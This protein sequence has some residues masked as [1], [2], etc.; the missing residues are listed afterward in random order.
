VIHALKFA[1]S[2][3]TPSA[4]PYVWETCR[5]SPPFTSSAQTSPA[6]HRRPS[7]CEPLSPFHLRPLDLDQTARIES[8]NRIGTE[9]SCASRSLLIRRPQLLIRPKRYP[10]MR[11]CR[12]ACSDSNE[13]RFRNLNQ[14]SVQSSEIHILCS[15]DPKIANDIPLESLKSV[16]PSSTIKSYILWVQF[17]TN[18]KL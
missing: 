3:W 13:F 2:R 1:K 10:P 11:N 4:H 16:E 17:E 14:N 15:V 6:T 5:T 18:F 9:Q 8:L 12:V 7:H